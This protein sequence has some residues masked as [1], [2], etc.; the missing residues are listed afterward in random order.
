MQQKWFSGIDPMKYLTL[1]LESELQAAG[2][3]MTQWLTSEQ[4]IRRHV[5]RVLKGV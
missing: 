2:S 4:G 1:Q 5:E 3:K